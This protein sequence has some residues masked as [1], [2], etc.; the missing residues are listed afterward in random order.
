MCVEEGEWYVEEAFRKAII[1]RLVRFL[2]AKH[3]QFREIDVMGIS[4]EEVRV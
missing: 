4:V 2:V 1:L 3:H